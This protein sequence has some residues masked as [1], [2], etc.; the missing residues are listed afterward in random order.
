MKDNLGNKQLIT[1]ED[2]EKFFK[3]W[4]MYVVAVNPGAG[5]GDEVGD[6]EERSPTSL[7]LSAILNIFE[8]LAQVLNLTQRHVCINAYC[9]RVNKDTKVT[10]CLF[11]IPHR[12][13]TEPALEKP[14][15]SSLTSSWLSAMTRG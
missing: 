13:C 8:F 7:P 12:N 14:I 5:R 6:Y 3:F 15:G 2:R 10:E 4:G 9:Q 1:E 11:R